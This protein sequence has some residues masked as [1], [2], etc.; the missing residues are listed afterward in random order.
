MMGA[1]RRSMESPFDETKLLLV[2]EFL[3]REFRDCHHR[4]FFAFDRT[5]QV[6]LIET[7]RGFRHM[8]VVPKDT[9]ED[10]DLGR[11]CNAEL[12]T[13]LKLAR[14]GRVML[15]PHGPVVLA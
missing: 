5:A 1:D 12:A 11:L 7:G 13:T 15:T 8:L 2:R 10:A 3:Y 9:F 4:D 6:F 14:E